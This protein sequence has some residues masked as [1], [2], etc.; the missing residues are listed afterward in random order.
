MNN[1][2]PSFA[3]TMPAVEKLLTVEQKFYEAYSK[4][5]AQSPTHGRFDEHIR[6]GEIPRLIE[7][8]PDMPLDLHSVITMISERANGMLAPTKE[9]LDALRLLDS[10]KQKS[11]DGESALIANIRSR[12][13]Q[14][15]R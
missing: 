4:A 6:S 8:Y 3:R 14:S 7:Q 11:T 12:Y 15:M 1:P 13:L 10:I 9:Y 2:I 5:V